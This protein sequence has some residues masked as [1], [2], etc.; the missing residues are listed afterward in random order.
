MGNNALHIQY[1]EEPVYK[2]F[3][4]GTNRMI[5]PEESL[6]KLKAK[7]PLF[8]ITRVANITGLDHIGIPVVA[9]Y[10]PNS[11]SIAVSQGKGISLA[12]AK[13][14]GI[15]ESIE[16]YHAEHISK[17]LLFGSYNDLKKKNNLV[18]VDSL[19]Q[20]RNSRFHND[21]QLLWVEGFDLISKADYWVPFE[22]VNMSSRLPVPSG[23][24][25]FPS[26][27]NGLASG[28]H[29]QEAILHSICEAIERDSTTL[30]E[31]RSDEDKAKTRIRLETIKDSYCRTVLDQLFK[32][33]I[34]VAVWETTSDI[35]VPAFL[36][37]ITNDFKLSIHAVHSFTGMGCHVNKAIALSRAVT[38]AVQCRLTI[39]SGA[40]DD[41][42]HSD[43]Q[44]FFQGDRIVGRYER[45]LEFEETR[46]FDE[47]I[48]FEGGTFGEDINFVLNR[49]KEKN[50]EN[51]I[52][53]N[54]TKEEFE[55][56]VV[57][58]IIP[59]LE[60]PDDDSDYVAGKRALKIK[61]EL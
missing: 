58:T 24:G 35:G 45:L 6:E 60:G 48:S 57:K 61:E 42:N 52:A 14:S 4:A 53:V 47:V 15:M 1:I 38:E 25:C 32:E 23:S 5:S 20:V 40:R 33:K 21:L 31:I 11:R 34:Q 13:V 55:I 37:E 51:V 9:V 8:K 16:L 59:G 54:L 50:I 29:I 49:L 18:N 10:R 39:I 46:N 36:C 26:N 3:S 12:S 7:L 43:Y 41:L 17:P 27:S 28:N 44:N 30:W 56:P 2:K 22:L 19:T